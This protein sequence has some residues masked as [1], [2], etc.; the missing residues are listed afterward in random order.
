MINTDWKNHGMNVKVI[1][2]YKLEEKI[3]THNYALDAKT[4]RMMIEPKNM[5]LL[6]FDKTESTILDVKHIPNL[7]KDD[8]VWVA[9]W[10]QIVHHMRPI[11]MLQ[12]INNI[13]NLKFLILKVE[14]KNAEFDLLNNVTKR[15]P[16]ATLFEGLVTWNWGKMVSNNQ[17]ENLERVLEYTIVEENPNRDIV[18][19]FSACTKHSVPCI[20]CESI[21]DWTKQ[22]KLKNNQTLNDLKEIKTRTLQPNKN[23]EI[24][25]YVSAQ[26]F[27]GPISASWEYDNET[28]SV[29]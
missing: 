14:D 24:D 1:S 15:Y 11:G 8:T 28:T 4:K 25:E 3:E 18:T 5:R 12:D 13:A 27:E 9:N 19:K 6:G 23:G 21:L 17:L 22:P 29:K 20:T 26:F 2:E 16:Y 10:D 7:T